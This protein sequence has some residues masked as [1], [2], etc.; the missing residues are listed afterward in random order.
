MERRSFLLFLP[1]VA[2][3]STLR[4][5]IV[6]PE[7]M[8]PPLPAPKVAPP[9]GLARS[10]PPG[11]HQ[12][13]IIGVS[14]MIT[15]RGR[16]FPIRMRILGTEDE[17]V[18]V[19]SEGAPAHAASFIESATKRKLDPSKES[20]LELDSLKGLDM[21]VK[22]EEHEDCK[23]GMKHDM[24]TAHAFDPFPRPRR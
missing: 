23:S 18:S 12:V 7:S 22:I 13:K 20:I 15:E 11:W 10:L 21:Y 4:S 14:E 8:M 2:A 9:L 19:L 3:A 17:V 24:V 5:R 6:V 16:H 1:W